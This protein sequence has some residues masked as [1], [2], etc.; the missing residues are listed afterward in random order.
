VRSALIV[1]RLILLGVKSN[2]ARAKGA[3][4]LGIATGTAQKSIGKPNA[5]SNV[6]KSHARWCPKPH[7]LTFSHTRTFSQKPPRAPSQFKNSC[8]NLERQAVELST[9][10]T[11]L[12]S[13]VEKRIEERRR[14]LKSN[15][16]AVKCMCCETRK[17]GEA[18]AVGSC[19]VCKRSVKESE[20]HPDDVKEL[21]GTSPQARLA[22]KI[23]GMVV[24]PFCC[25]SD[26]RTNPLKWDEEELNSRQASQASRADAAGGITGLPAA[27]QAS[28]SEDMLTFFRTVLGSNHRQGI[29]PSAFNMCAISGVCSVQ[30]R[31]TE[32]MEAVALTRLMGT[33]CLT[34]NTCW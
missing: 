10:M 19:F 16:T 27:G 20:L 24:V 26:R 12:R 28:P 2:S 18:I 8:A 13:D 29:E 31:H 17:R 30:H 15:N 1:V 14:E 7:Y 25:F 33:T 5:N 21:T 34:T 6:L 22:K 9:T 32:L 11:N 3:M 23:R 4:S